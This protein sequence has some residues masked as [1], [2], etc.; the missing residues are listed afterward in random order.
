M[1]KVIA[2]VLFLAI[3][4]GISSCGDE[5]KNISTKNS[6]ENYSLNLE[7][8][9][10]RNNYVNFSD[11]DKIILDVNSSELDYVVEQDF[12]LDNGQWSIDLIQLPMD[13]D[14]TFKA[15]AFIN[16]TYSYISNHVLKLTTGDNNITMDLQEENTFAA[17][18][19]QVQSMES[20]LTTLDD[21][22]YTTVTFKIYNVLDDDLSYI[23]TDDD[24]NGTL[25]DPA[26]GVIN[27]YDGNHVGILDINYTR[28]EVAGTYRN[29]I[30]LVSTNGDIFIYAFDLTVND[31]DEVFVVINQPAEI[32]GFIVTQ[33]DQNLSVEVNATDPDG[34][35]AS[36]SY[37]W[38]LTDETGG[39]ALDSAS[40]TTSIAILTGF[41]DGDG[42]KLTVEITDSNNSISTAVYK[43][44]K[45]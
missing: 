40:S 11:I 21:V 18:K 23:I 19:V 31:N 16:G 10:M 17:N 15:R 13:K 7:I 24:G 9:T 36:L 27:S 41:D 4:I 20:T 30:K 44:N 34:D 5:N 32:D 42:A 1:K 14:L 35:D 25:F 38:V 43:I 45:D 28:P 39:V 26:S 22:N 6:Y 33:E 37:E 2:F 29:R 12:I 8:K 3:S